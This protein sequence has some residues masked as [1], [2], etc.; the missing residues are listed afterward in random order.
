M[1]P[2]QL[3]ACRRPVRGQ[4]PVHEAADRRAR[5]IDAVRDARAG[6]DL[7]PP[8]QVGCGAADDQ[9]AVIGEVGEEGVEDA[10]ADGVDRDVEAARIFRREHRRHVFRLVIDHPL[11]A[12]RG[13]EIAF[14]RAPADADDMTAAQQR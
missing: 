8:L 3:V 1:E 13:D 5:V 9:P 14:A 11:R 2:E 12:E 6:D 10:A 7:G 4:Q